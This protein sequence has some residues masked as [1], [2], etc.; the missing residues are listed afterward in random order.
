MC[1]KYKSQPLIGET[2]FSSVT[3]SKSLSSDSNPWRA[4][5]SPHALLTELQRN[6]D[7]VR[8]AALCAEV[9]RHCQKQLMQTLIV[10][11]LETH[12]YADPSL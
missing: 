7:I 11:L 5:D 3:P 12:F 9:Q 2:L 4:L 6:K 1:L 10:R 8:C